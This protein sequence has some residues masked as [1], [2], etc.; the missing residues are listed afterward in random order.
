MTLQPVKS[1]RTNGRGALSVR[2]LCLLRRQ[3]LS[4][5]HVVLFYPLANAKS[6]F[7]QISSGVTNLHESAGRTKACEA[8]L[9]PPVN[10]PGLSQLMG[11]VFTALSPAS[12]CPS[13]PIHLRKTFHEVAINHPAK[14]RWQ[15]SFLASPLPSFHQKTA[16][17]AASV[18]SQPHARPAYLTALTR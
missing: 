17:S 15:Q 4:G 18:I 1:S 5:N 14:R 9:L 3:T 6:D 16:R 11:G 13:L 10:T 2:L 7:S 8:V 12:L